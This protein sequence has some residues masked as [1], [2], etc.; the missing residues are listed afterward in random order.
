MTQVTDN[1]GTTKLYENDKINV[2]LFELEPGESTDM[3]TH[4]HSYLWFGIAGG[5]LDCHDVDGNPL[6]I[7]DVPTDSIWDIKCNGDGTLTVMSG[8][9]KGTPFPATHVAKNVGE[10]TYRELLIE[11]KDA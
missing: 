10:T 1:L 4:R 8:E 2:W 11:F 5:P 6:G 3:H 9:A 7:F